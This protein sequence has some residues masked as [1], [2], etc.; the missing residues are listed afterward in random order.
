MMNKKS[1]F[2]IGIASII[3]GLGFWILGKKRLAGTAA[4]V[5][6]G[7]YVI[8]VA[9]PWEFLYALSCNVAI[10]GWFL[11]IVYAV[12]E[13]QAIKKVTSGEMEAARP[14]ERK[15]EIPAD[16]P[17]REKLPYKAKEI[18]RE[19][20]DPGEIIQDAIMV[21]T[22]SYMRGAS[23][24]KQYYLGLLS[25]QLML[26]GTDLFGKPVSVKRIPFYKI[27]Q[28]KFKKG[29]INDQ[30]ILSVAGEKKIRLNINRIQR[31]HTERFREVLS[32]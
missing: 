23:S 1:P 5:V 16:I 13:A 24:M 29:L 8:Y 20:L 21:F 25:D 19:Q 3:P 27:D 12:Y 6:I 28:A 11:Q 14:S 4:V 26:V 15:I 18:I 9:A 10:I 2:I 31:E 22:M 17:R 7:A 30:I 32:G